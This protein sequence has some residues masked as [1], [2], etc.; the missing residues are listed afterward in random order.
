MN[1]DYFRDLPNELPMNL[2]D[3]EFKIQAQMIDPDYVNDDNE[4]GKIKVIYKSN[5]ASGGE[6]SWTNEDIDLVPCESFQ[7]NPWDDNF[8][9]PDWSD[10]HVMFANYQYTE[11]AWTRLLVEKCDTEERALLGKTCKS[12]DEINEY[13]ATKLFQVKAEME[14]P[15]L[16]SKNIS[17]FSRKVQQDLFFQSTINNS[18]LIGKEFTVL[19]NKIVLEDNMLGIIDEEIEH[20]IIDI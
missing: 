5:L 14:L 2:K 6:E 12:E 16:E 19:R 13:Y 1:T 17:T 20:E 10:E 9:C 15:E 3:S 7:D 8:L 18:T 4:Y 11:T